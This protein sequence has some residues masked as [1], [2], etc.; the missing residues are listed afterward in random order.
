MLGIFDA[1]TDFFDFFVSCIDTGLSCLGWALNM[2]VHAFSFLYSL[3]SL[4]PI[5]MI[6]GGIAI[7][8]IAV[9]YKILGREEQ[10]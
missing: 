1:I 6:G 4:L 9:L 7:I 5:E 10:S 3:V 2:I 8:V